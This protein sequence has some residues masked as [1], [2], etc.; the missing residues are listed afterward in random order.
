ME[1]TL[2]PIRLQ[3]ITVLRCKIYQ[4]QK[5]ALDVAT[6]KWLRM[7]SEH[8]GQLSLMLLL[9][10]GQS[11]SQIL[12]ALCST[13]FDVTRACSALTPYGVWFSGAWLQGWGPKVGK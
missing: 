5:I 3:M 10:V 4:A 8:P 11:G 7:L 12:A 6:T 9:S 13:E 2:S 1:Q